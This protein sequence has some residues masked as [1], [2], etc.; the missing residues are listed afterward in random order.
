V[1][2]QSLP[3]LNLA[4]LNF[5]ATA[6]EVHERPCSR[7]CSSNDHRATRRPLDAMRSGQST[8]HT[9]NI[10]ESLG[11]AAE[12]RWALRASGIHRRRIDRGVNMDRY[13]DHHV[14]A[15][16]PGRALTSNK[17]HERRVR[18]STAGAWGRLE[19][20]RRLHDAI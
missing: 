3:E 7:G 11:D 17:L 9:F 13:L 2:L 8:Q 15:R 5:A 14:L 16:L 19:H 12:A 6:V 1:D 18:E 10:R 20:P 4:A